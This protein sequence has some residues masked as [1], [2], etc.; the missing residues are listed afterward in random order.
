MDKLLWI[1]IDIWTGG[2]GKDAMQFADISFTSKKECVQYVKLNYESLNN[3]V[4]KE[5][6]SHPD[7][8]NIFYCTTPKKWQTILNQKYM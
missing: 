1:I 6:Y 8:P 5:F 4:N 3:D 7:T 2:D